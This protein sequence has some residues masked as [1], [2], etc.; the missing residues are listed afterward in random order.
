MKHQLVIAIAP[1]TELSGQNEAKKRLTFP[2]FS[3]LLKSFVFWQAGSDAGWLVYV[4]L[5]DSLLMFLNKIS[6]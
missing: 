2:E 6:A 1:R 4:G 5:S 3:F